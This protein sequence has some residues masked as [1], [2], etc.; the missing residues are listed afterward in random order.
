MTQAHQKHYRAC[1][2]CEAICGLEIETKDQQVISIRGD[3]DDPVSQGYLCPKGTALA[4]IHHD[5]DRLRVPHKRVGNEWVK[6]S[7]EEALD[8]AADRLID[9]QEK[10]G[11]SS[12]G[13]Y[14]GNPN[15]HNYGSM[16][17]GPNFRR[18]FGSKNHFSATSLDQLPHQLVA[19]AMLGHQFA[20]P[21]PD[22]N[23]TQLMV[24]MGGN[25]MASNGSIMT[26][27]N[28]PKRLRAIKER[29]GKLVVID[30]R[31]TETANIATEHLFIK[32]GS[33]AY[34]LMAMIR[35]I[36][37]ENWP[38]ST[39]LDPVLNGLDIVKD[40][41]QPFTLG[42]AEAVSGIP[43]D[44]IYQLTKE[45]VETPKAVLYGRMGVSVQEFGTIC[46]WAIQVI[47]IL[48]GAT[49]HVGGALLTSPA[50]AYVTKG[51]GGAGH[52]DRYKSR[53]RGLPEFSG[54]FPAAALAEEIL[55]PGEGQIK[56]M[57][58]IAGN[59]VISTINSNTIEE[60]FASL[61]FY[62][63]ID[64]YINATTRHADLILPPTSPLEHDHFDI[65]FLRFAIHNSVR[66]NP[67]VFEPNEGQLHDW[68]IFNGLGRRIAERKTLDFNE[69]PPPDLLI[70]MGVELDVYGPKK[71]PEMALTLEKIKAAPHGIDLGPLKPSLIERIATDDGLINCAPDFLIKDLKRLETKP[72]EHEPDTLLLIGRRHLRSNNSWMHNS[73]RL[74]KGPARWQLMMHPTDLTMRGITDGATVTITSRVGTVQTIV[75]A[76]D[77]IMPGVVSLP[78]GWG[79]N[80]EG[81]RMQIATQQLGVNCNELTDHEFLDTLS[82]NAALNGIPVTVAATE[83]T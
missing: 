38:K 10:H 6:I 48:I 12:V 68:E 47:N 77:T 26:M 24:I 25:P 50:F 67:A 27:P 32:P 20:I 29:G 49:D 79:H 63:A 52:F 56:A 35:T 70:G 81:V 40:A 30:P 80:K 3:K 66:M 65:A 11:N 64:F 59:P 42:L 15:V 33:D 54:E 83:G 39:H 62:V 69:L 36:F 14:A 4:D 76:T 75:S 41:S 19:L 28:A 18:V 74:V 46:Q 2:L 43:A 58:T 57:I 51:L 60:A 23:N 31:K 72:V 8:Y 61:D 7:W 21:I 5:P 9:I 17:H 44:K 16:T 22:V 82:G 55:T 45:L 53:V 13:F 73:Q 1:H 37:E 71:N 34:V 78:H